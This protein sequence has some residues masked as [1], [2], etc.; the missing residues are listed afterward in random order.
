[1]CVGNTCLTRKTVKTKRVSFY[2]TNFKNK[3]KKKNSKESKDGY[4]KLGSESKIRQHWRQFGLSKNGEM[5][6]IG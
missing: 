3:N 5:F 6:C 4:W 2:H 1:M